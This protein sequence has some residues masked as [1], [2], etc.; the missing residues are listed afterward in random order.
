MI[1]SFL[2][3]K[4]LKNCLPLLTFF[5][6]PQIDKVLLNKRMKTTSFQVRNTIFQIID[7]DGS[8]LVKTFNTGDSLKQ[9]ENFVM[10]TRKEVSSDE[11]S[12]ESEGELEFNRWRPA[13]RGIEIIGFRSKYPDKEFRPNSSD[14]GKTLKQLGLFHLQF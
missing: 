9:V 1:I 14:Y 10:S 4:I 8:K 3:K 2:V 11:S 7:I 5:V 13:K 6:Y 12:S